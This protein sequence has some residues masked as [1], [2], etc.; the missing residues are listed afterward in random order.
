M[1][2]YTYGQLHQDPYE[3]PRHHTHKP[4]TLTHLGGGVYV[5]PPQDKQQR[6]V[7][8][9]PLA[10][11]V[12][13]RQA[14]LSGV[15]DVGLEVEQQQ[16]AVLVA[17]ARGRVERGLA[18]LRVRGEKFGGRVEGGIRHYPV[19]FTPCLRGTPWPPY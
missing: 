18:I 14:V 1:G 5:S 16:R 19:Q 9:V 11:A 13:R 10:G 12:Q 17:A 3:S 6:D 4:T 15:V 2:S 8:V 7:A